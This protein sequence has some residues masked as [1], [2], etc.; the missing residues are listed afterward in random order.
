MNFLKS[1][2]KRGGNVLE[3]PIPSFFFPL[4]IESLEDLKKKKSGPK[5]GGESTMNF[6]QNTDIY[7]RLSE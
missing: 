3:N 2:L 5:L 4:G 1:Y 6:H 7:L